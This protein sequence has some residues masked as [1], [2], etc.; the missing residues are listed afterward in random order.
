MRYHALNDEPSAPIVNSL[1][2]WVLLAALSYAG[3]AAA[4]DTPIKIDRHHPPRIGFDYY[5]FDSKRLHEQG[6][7]KVKMTVGADGVIRDIK[8]TL[9]TGFAR[10]DDACLQ[11]FAH[12]GLLPAMVDGEP[13][14]ASIELPITWKITPAP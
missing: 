7:C 6:M 10:L 11:A 2:P 13:I 12:G 1:R 3:I 8:L 4:S 5:P 14:D 9:S